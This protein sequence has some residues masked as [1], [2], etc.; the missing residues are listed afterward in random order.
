MAGK[1]RNM[2]LKLAGKNHYA[3]GIIGN[4]PQFCLMD[5]KGDLNAKS[6]RSEN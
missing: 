1:E 3:G 2:V 6:D 4:V 5:E